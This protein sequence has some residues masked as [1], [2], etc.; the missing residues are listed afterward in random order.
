MLRKSFWIT[1]KQAQK[2]MRSTNLHLMIC[3]DGVGSKPMISNTTLETML[4]CMRLQSHVPR[5]KIHP[6]VTSKY[7]SSHKPSMRKGKAH[8]SNKGNTGRSDQVSPRL[9]SKSLAT[10][11]EFTTRIVCPGTQS[12]I[13][14]PEE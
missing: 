1:N 8:I 14:S 7:E 10:V 13:S 6:S 3:S 11:M 4:A 2:F 12:D 5:V 9:S